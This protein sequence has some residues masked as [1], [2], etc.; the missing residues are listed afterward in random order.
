MLDL[1]VCSE[2]DRHVYPDGERCPFCGAAAPDIV[3]PR[4][5]ARGLSRSAM[6][7]AAATFGASLAACSSSGAVY[8]APASGGFS[9]SAGSGGNAGTGTGGSAGAS[10]GQ[11]GAGGAAGAAGAP[12]NCFNDFQTIQGIIDGDF[13]SEKWE[14]AS[15]G[16]DTVDPWFINR[17]LKPRGQVRFIGD[18]LLDPFKLPQG[19][20]VVSHS[21]LLTPPSSKLP[22]R[23]VCSGPGELE[24]NQGVQEYRMTQAKVLEACSGKPSSGSILLCS[25][26]KCTKNAQGSIDGVPVAD[27]DAKFS[28][29]SVA[30]PLIQ[31][32]TSDWRVIVYTDKA[33]SSGATGAVGHGLLITD[34]KGPHGGAVYCS[35]VGATWQWVG[36]QGTIVDFKTL[37]KIGVCGDA[38]GTTKLRFCF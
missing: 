19:K 28:G 23:F 30:D 32:E 16:G 20:H 1:I 18:K 37:V 6:V 9:G 33:L 36:A 21:Y 5:L 15:I 25:G 17:E 22:N 4:K 3:A 26:A 38:S 11:G 27:K 31:G 13:I 35:G 8:G 24:V 29:S 14:L 7:A 12:S 34:P 2:C 10:G